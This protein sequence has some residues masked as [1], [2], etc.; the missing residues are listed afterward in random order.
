MTKQKAA[1][2]LEPVGSFIKIFAIIRKWSFN[3]KNIDLT[4]STKKC[5]EKY[6]FVMKVVNG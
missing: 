2:L 4:N 5:R 1:F 3:M 6:L